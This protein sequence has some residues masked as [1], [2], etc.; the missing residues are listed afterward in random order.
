MKQ[1]CKCALQEHLAKHL[2]KVRF[3][4]KLTQDKFAEM[5]MINPRSYSNLESGRNCCC[6]LTFIMFLAFCCKDV[7]AFVSE[8]R[9][10]IL[11]VISD[12]EKS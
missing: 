6:T 1:A 7:D 2:A 10:I 12:P 4:E 9:S 5:L 3:E 8:L 11:N